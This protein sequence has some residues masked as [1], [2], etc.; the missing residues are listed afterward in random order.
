MFVNGRLDVDNY[1]KS[2][3]GEIFLYRIAFY[4]GLT[5]FFRIYC[6]T[7]SAIVNWLSVAL[8]NNLLAGNKGIEQLNGLHIQKCLVPIFL[9]S[10]SC[11]SESSNPESSNPES[12]NPE[13][14]NPESSNPG[15]RVS[16]NCKLQ[17]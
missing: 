4:P 6:S 3:E 16:L 12:S 9:N 15:F 8:V 7:L 10:E 14:S 1:L 2:P 11:N 17:N 5:D 13:S